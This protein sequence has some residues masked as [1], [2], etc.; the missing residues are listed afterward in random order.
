MAYPLEASKDTVEEYSINQNCFRDLLL[1][2]K[3]TSTPH[4]ETRQFTNSKFIELYY[5]NKWPETNI[6][7]NKF[8]F[9]FVTYKNYMRFRDFMLKYCNYFKK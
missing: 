5:E 1:Q 3:T 6:K 7:I 2:S 8:N 9:H 4:G